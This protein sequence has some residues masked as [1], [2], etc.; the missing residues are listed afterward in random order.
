[1]QQIMVKKAALIFDHQC[2]ECLGVTGLGSADQLEIFKRLRG[3]DSIRG[4]FSYWT[5]AHK[6]GRWFNYFWHDPRS[7]SKRSDVFVLGS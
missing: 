2:A 6:R 7:V 4:Q 1:M 3:F 5:V